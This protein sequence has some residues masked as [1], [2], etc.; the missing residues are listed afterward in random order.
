MCKFTKNP[1]Q[2]QSSVGDYPKILHLVGAVVTLIKVH[3][4]HPGI[5]DVLLAFPAV[6]GLALRPVHGMAGCVKTEK[7]A[8][9]GPPSS[10]VSTAAVAVKFD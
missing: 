3:V 8:L 6:E 2:L 10:V 4:K 9:A 1:A 7:A 5:Q